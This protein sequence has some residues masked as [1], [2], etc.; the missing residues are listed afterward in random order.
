MTD[1]KH[2]VCNFSD[3]NDDHAPSNQ[4][5]FNYGSELVKHIRAH[6]GNDFVIGVAGN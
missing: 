1:T 5:H 6:H 2:Y 3:R 4:P